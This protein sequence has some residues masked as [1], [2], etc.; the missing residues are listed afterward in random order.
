MMKELLKYVEQIQMINAEIYLEQ[1]AQRP[2]DVIGIGISIVANQKIIHYLLLVLLLV[3]VLVLV[4]LLTNV[5]TNKVK[6]AV[7]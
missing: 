5:L 1:N 7:V 3:L 2:L 6:L 4:P